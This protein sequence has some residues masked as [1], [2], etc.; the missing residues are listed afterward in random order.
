MNKQHQ[1]IHT[2]TQKQA[3]NHDN[4]APHTHGGTNNGSRMMRLIGLL[5]HE[6]ESLSDYRNPRL[7]L[8]SNH[9]II[10]TMLVLV[11][12]MVL[13]HLL[14]ANLV[15]VAQVVIIAGA[16]HLAILVIGGL[17]GTLF[18]RHQRTTSR[19]MLIGSIPW[20]GTEK[21][22]DVGCGTGMMLNGCAQ[23]LTTGRAIGID[24]W[25]QPIAGSTSVLLKNA[26]AEGVADKVEY[27]EMDARHL[28]FEDASFNV[29]VSS[30]ALHHIGSEREDRVRAVNQMVRVLKPGGYLSVLDIGPMIDIAETIISQTGLEIVTS[31]QT[32]FFRLVTAHKPV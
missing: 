31:R 10:G 20:S 27:Q 19:R 24:L 12:G 18:V 28:T 30:F 1:F 11:I 8:A 14:P 7:L 23:K 22:L 2:H 29:V 32:R 21:V 16:A 13:A 15:G 17:A 5:A 4:A 26:K 6:G 25:Q 3:H 9:V